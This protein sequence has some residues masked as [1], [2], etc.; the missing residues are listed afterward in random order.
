[1]SASN[2]TL[3]GPEDSLDSLSFKNSNANVYNQSINYTPQL[4]HHQP[5]QKIKQSSSEAIHQNIGIQH[6]VDPKQSLNYPQSP[7]YP[8]MSL[9][10]SYQK[11]PYNM[12]YQKQ[13]DPLSNLGNS[14][15][16]NNAKT[17]SEVDDSYPYLN[18]KVFSKND[19][20][21][22]DM[23]NRNGKS[24]EDLFIEQLNAQEYDSLN[25]L[26]KIPKSSEL[27]ELKLNQYKELSKLR[28]Q[29]K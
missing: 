25:L 1:M 22:T 9:G 15:R 4:S 3:K 16:S 29:Y 21:L 6:Y 28:D 12:Q 26:A 10:N 5:Y 14:R 18:P 7:K 8:T 23:L 13:S 20:L 17:E 11:D 19:K 24:E 2:P 27:Y